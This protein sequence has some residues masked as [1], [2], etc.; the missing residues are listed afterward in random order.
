M[1]IIILIIRIIFIILSP[2]IITENIIIPETMVNTRNTFV[3]EA[4]SSGVHKMM[5]TLRGY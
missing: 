4:I 3:Y 1:P 2:E 5:K